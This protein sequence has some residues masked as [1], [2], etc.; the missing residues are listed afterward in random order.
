MAET[1]PAAVNP[2]AVTPAPV[3]SPEIREALR[4]FHIAA[5]VVGVALLVLVVAMILRYGFDQRWA[6]ATWGPI[7]G[8]LYFAYFVV[9][10]S[11]SFKARWGPV[12][13]LLVIL[14][15]TVPVASFWVDKVVCRKVL[16]GQRL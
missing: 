7:H 6:V 11:L 5:M 10:L 13:T 12:G 14:A 3:V 15:G 1:T 8:A 9:V 4:R 2:A 16:A